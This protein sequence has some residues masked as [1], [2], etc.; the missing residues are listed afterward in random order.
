MSDT[1]TQTMAAN[2][3][4]AKKMLSASAAMWFIVATFGQWFFA[5]YI[6]AFYG[7]HAVDGNW[8]A[9]S[10]RM[11]HGFIEGDIIGNVAV[12]IHIFLAFVI[13][14]CGPL[15]F[16]PQVRKYSP[17]FHRFNGRLYIMTAL[18]I[19]VAAI[20]SVWTRDNRIGGLTGQIAT[21]LDGV[22]IIVCAIMTVRL[23]MARQ[24]ARHNRWAL[25]LF[26]VASGVWFYRVIR[27]F[28]ITVNDGTS[29]GTNGTL[30]GPFDQALNFAGFLMP[31]LI[32]EV[33]FRVRDNRA[34]T[35]KYAMSGVLMMLTV[36]MAVGI[37][38]AAN[39]LWLPN[40]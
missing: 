23:A 32:L 24:I 17:A 40:L 12:L 6:L 2:P 30:T 11:I 26:I 25:R 20:Y 28:W 8:L 38:G 7:G 29:P 9:W 35:G 4:T 13:T 36:I 27:G 37:Y 19:S 22:M 16:M 39:I 14:F 21:S 33:Y 15:Q 18:I 10:K 31:L 1:Y 34:D 5:Y 3:F